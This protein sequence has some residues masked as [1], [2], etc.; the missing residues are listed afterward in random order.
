MGNSGIE[1]E[2]ITRQ[3]SDDGH[4]LL[5]FIGKVGVPARPT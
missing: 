4:T 1:S 5:K 2:T 3:R